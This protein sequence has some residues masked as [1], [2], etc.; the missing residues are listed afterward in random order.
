M[1]FTANHNVEVDID[2]DEII[3]M[4]EGETYL[5]KVVAAWSREDELEGAKKVL[6]ARIKSLHLEE[7]DADENRK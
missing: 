1:K 7:G 4:L 2:F 3:D 6:D 5:E